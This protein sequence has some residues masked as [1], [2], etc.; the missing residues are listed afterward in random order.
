MERF[1]ADDKNLKSFKIS[2]TQKPKVKAPAKPKV[3][4][5]SEVEDTSL[6]FA[7]IEALLDK[8]TP[9]DVRRNLGALLT[10]LNEHEAEAK[11]QKAKAGV[12]RAKV[13]VERTQELLDYLFQTKESM[14]QAVEASVQGSDKKK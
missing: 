10:S 3:E 11:S 13:A 1:M 6:G 5:T 14:Q 4:E 2:E 9:D 12:K 7:R 8:D